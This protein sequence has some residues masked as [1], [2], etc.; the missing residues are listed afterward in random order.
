MGTCVV[1]LCCWFL[2]V[3]CVI[4]CL[5]E[6]V[7]VCLLVCLCGFL[8]SFEV[9]RLVDEGQQVPVEGWN[10]LRQAW[11]HLT[12]PPATAAAGPEHTAAQEAAAAAAGTEDTAAQLPAAAAE[13]ALLC[14]F[15]AWQLCTLLWASAKLGLRV[16]PP[17]WPNLLAH[18]GHVSAD[19]S[20]RDL[21]LT[22]WAL[23]KLARL[24]NF[25]MISQGPAIGV[26]VG[27]AGG[28][29]V[30]AAVKQAVQELLLQGG[31]QPLQAYPPR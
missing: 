13:A 28:Q 9:V 23:A 7:P 25:E 31:K 11:T 15:T 3:H 26:A 8:P 14:H 29:S 5:P 19:M 18:M 4:A 16:P 21:S 6:C 2:F 24:A 1:T 30:V 22:V 20:P 10:Q 17:A 27:R 12:T